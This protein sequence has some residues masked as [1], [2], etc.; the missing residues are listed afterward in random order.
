MHKEIFTFSLRDC[1]F[2]EDGY[3]DDTYLKNL[4]KIINDY[5]CKSRRIWFFGAGVELMIPA[6]EGEIDVYIDVETNPCD[7][8]GSE[9]SYSIKIKHGEIEISS[10]WFDSECIIALS[11]YVDSLTFS[12]LFKDEECLKAIKL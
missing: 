8:S 9:F 12:H 5:I 4:S 6:L 1:K 11:T 2:K 3:R 7:K 10:P